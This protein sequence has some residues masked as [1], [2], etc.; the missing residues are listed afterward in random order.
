MQVPEQVRN[1]D[2]RAISWG[3][4]Y[5]MGMVII[6][7]LVEGIVFS[8]LPYDSRGVG[9][10][11]SRDEYLVQGYTPVMLLGYI[12]VHSIKIAVPCYLTAQIAGNRK[13]LHAV[14]VVVIGTMI[15]WLL[16]QAILYTP[17]S[18]SI[19]IVYSVLVASLAA[20]AYEY[21]ASLTGSTNE[22]L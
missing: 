13:I 14:I 21:R 20:K 8:H 9:R 17:V 5:L 12:V 3:L 1:I 15:C 7:K 16:F 11:L 19:G 6:L 22:H 10:F 2:W 18:E 4:Y